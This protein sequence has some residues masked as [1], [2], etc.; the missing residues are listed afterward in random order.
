MGKNKMRNR[1]RSRLENTATSNGSDANNTS[2]PALS[3]LIVGKSR[4]MPTRAKPPKSNKTPSTSTPSA[5]GISL[6]SWL[7]TSDLITVNLSMPPFPAKDGRPSTLQ[8]PPTKNRW[9]SFISSIWEDTATWFSR[10][11]ISWP[12]RTIG[13]LYRIIVQ[14]AWN[15]WNDWQT[16][17]DMVLTVIFLII[18][19]FA[20]YIALELLLKALPGVAAQAFD[21]N[22]SVVYVTIPGP[23]ITI[24]LVAA[25]PTN[26]ARASPHPVDSVLSSHEH[27]I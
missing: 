13:W 20:C 21:G 24:S 8:T 22:C 18:T 11:L 17:T 26:P 23:I 7:P 3:P 25:S 14:L 27:Q 15:C 9:H 2:R 10:G 12:C 19:I 4:K 6:D 1:D 16:F 5:S